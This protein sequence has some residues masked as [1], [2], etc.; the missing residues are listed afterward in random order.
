VKT[1]IFN[2]FIDN[3]VAAI[4]FIDQWF[5]FKC[6]IFSPVFAMFCLWY[7]GAVWHRVLSNKRR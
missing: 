3:Y 4:V 2:D 5:F 6:F 1:I 7:P